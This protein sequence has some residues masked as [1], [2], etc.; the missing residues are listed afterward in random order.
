MSRGKK[1]NS[2]R[3]AESSGGEN[4]DAVTINDV[5]E[6]GLFDMTIAT[7]IMLWS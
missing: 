7:I 6:N 1:G 4:I 3:T 2:K 5:R